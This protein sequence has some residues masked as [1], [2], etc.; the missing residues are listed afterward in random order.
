MISE[1]SS[2]AGYG[3]FLLYNCPLEQLWPRE[4]ERPLKEEPELRKRSAPMFA[5]LSSTDL[6]KYLVNTKEE[7]FSESTPAHL[8]IRSGELTLEVGTA[9]DEEE[10]SKVLRAVRNA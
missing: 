4:A 7:G 1:A 5:R 8:R 3:S 10:P 2:F 6:I 9:L